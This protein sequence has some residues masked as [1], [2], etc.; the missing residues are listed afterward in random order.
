MNTG[1]IEGSI[2]ATQ[3]NEVTM[4]TDCRRAPV[5]VTG[6]AG[7]VGSH[8]VRKLLARGERVR[9]VDQL[10]YGSHGL[11][12]V[13]T[14]PRLEL[15]QGDV[16]DPAT[17]RDA[18]SGVERVIA[19]AALVGDAACDLD[20]GATHSI[21]LEATEVLADACARAGV[22]R[23]VFASTCSVYGANGSAQ[24]RE[25]SWLNPVSSYARTRLA[26]EEILRPRASDQSI[27]VL[28]LATVFGWSSRMRF[29]LLVNTFSA[30]AWFRR[31]IRVFGGSQWRPNL[32]VRDAA[33]AFILASLAPDS[34]ARGEVFNVGSD[35]ENHTVMEIAQ[36]VQAQLPE[37]EI[38]TAGDVVDRRDYRV[39]F[40]KIRRAL[41]F[42]T[43]FRVEDGIA[44]I[45]DRLRAGEI[46]NPDEP[47]YHNYQYLRTHGF[48]RA[49]TPLVT[50]EP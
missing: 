45:I 30:H 16:R 7:F 33:E 11:A 40:E 41:G 22:K 14:N 20:P 32:H 42:V 12:G 44:E 1:R 21:N 9:V 17:M 19:L 35:G 5:L 8:V 36:L 3:R 26:S 39:S 50:T 27:V 2:H 43:R 28:R 29:D 38:E 25:D 4:H 10:L 6:G 49:S 23:V 34:A 18:V 24:L 37:T 31:K 47:R 46:A 15:V 13:L 48:S